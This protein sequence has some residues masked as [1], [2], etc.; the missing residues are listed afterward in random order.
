MMHPDRY[1][2]VDLDDIVARRP[3]V[4]LVP[5]E[6]YEFRDGT[7]TSCATRSA[8]RVP[9]VRIDGQDL[10]WWGSR[11]PGAM[12]R[13]RAQLDPLIRDLSRASGF[14]GCRGSTVAS[15][16]AASSD[17]RRVAC[18]TAWH[19]T[20]HAAE[21]DRDR[22]RHAR[23][24]FRPGPPPRHRLHVADDQLARRPAPTAGRPGP[25]RHPVRQPRLRA[26]VASWTGRAPTRWRC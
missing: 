9:V 26:V 16:T 19:A 4:V 15:S 20:H 5:S 6:P 24:T 1:P 2:T 12:S 23:L 21:R 18:N 25:V 3:G 10:F 7:S 17:W 13:L 8:P 22:I 14:D 11:T